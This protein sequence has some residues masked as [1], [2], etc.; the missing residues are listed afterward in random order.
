[1]GPTEFNDNT[2]KIEAKLQKG[3]LELVKSHKL[4]SRLSNNNSHWFAKTRINGLPKTHKIGIPLRPILSMIDSAHYEL[5]KRLASLLKPVL[6]T[7]IRRRHPFT[8]QT[9]RC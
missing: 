2:I 3:L 1:M 8:K 9:K 4:L 5:T 6:E 7:S